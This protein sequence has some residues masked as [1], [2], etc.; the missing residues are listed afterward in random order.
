MRAGGRGY[1][2]GLVAQHGHVRR[3]ER[4]LSGAPQHIVKLRL[5]RCAALP[6]AVPVLLRQ[7]ARIY[8]KKKKRT[9]R[10][11][12]RRRRRRRRK[13]KEEK[14]E[15]GKKKKKKKKKKRRKRRNGGTIKQEV[16]DAT[17]AN[18][19]RERQRR[20]EGTGVNK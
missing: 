13:K 1:Q 19:T 17:T 16:E 10:K 2:E 3:R 9:R 5:D 20:A 14:K 15:E 6:D 4:R 11:G 12:R 18:N 8:P 7:R